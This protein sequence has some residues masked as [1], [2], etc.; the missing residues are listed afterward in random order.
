MWLRHSHCILTSFTFDIPTVSSLVHS[1]D[2]IAPL[3]SAERLVP[4]GG[5][6]ANRTADSFP[7]VP[8]ADRNA[9]SPEAG[10]AKRPADP[11]SPFL[12]PGRR[13]RSQ[14][15]SHRAP[16]AAST[17]SRLVGAARR[18]RV[19]SPT[20]SRGPKACRVGGDERRTSAPSTPGPLEITTFRRR[21][22]VVHTGR[23][24]TEAV[25]VASPDGCSEG[26]AC[27]LET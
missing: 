21:H 25:S 1:Y 4:R 2:N 22:G 9:G 16:T 8:V 12:R 10:L 17:H 19:T 26:S 18:P 15:C 11:R 23:N 5:T 14:R 20:P 13:C 6:R 27:C 3:Y 7:M 24:R